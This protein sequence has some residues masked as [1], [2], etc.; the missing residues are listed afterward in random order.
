MGRRD[1]LVAWREVVR[2]S[3]RPNAPDRVRIEHRVRGSFDLP[4]LLGLQ[5]SQRDLDF[6]TKTAHLVSAWRSAVAAASAK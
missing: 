4:V 2:K 5:G 3:E 6:E 1:A